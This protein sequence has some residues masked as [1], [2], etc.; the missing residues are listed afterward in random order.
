MNK[1]C[2]VLQVVVFLI[3]FFLLLPSF[4][5]SHIYGQSNSVASLN[6]ANDSVYSV[7]FYF[8]FK[9]D[10]LE[11]GYLTNMVSIVDVEKVLT[12]RLIFNSIDSIVVI[13]GTSPDG[14]FDYTKD[15]LTERKIEV[16]T[17]IH[18]KYPTIEREKVRISSTIDNQYI[19]KDLVEGD[20]NVPNQSAVLEILNQDLPFASIIQQLKIVDGGKSWDYMKSNLF[21]FMRMGKATIYL[22]REKSKDIERVKAELIVQ[23]DNKELVGKFIDKMIPEKS[24]DFTNVPAKTEY[25]YVRPLALKTNLLFDL[26]TIVNI[27]AEIPLSKNLSIAGECVFPWWLDEKKQR[28][29]EILSGSLEL[30]YWLNQEAR[31]QD[32]S[33]V[34]HNPL[35]GW[36]LG[37]YTG[38]GLYDLE[39][40]GKGYQGEFFIATG[41]SGGYVKPLSRNLNMEFSLGIGYLKTD[42]RRYEAQQDANKEWHLIKKNEGT[43]SWIGPIKAKVS[44]VWYPHFKKKGGRK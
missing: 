10:L 12:N 41:L 22:S 35:A 23:E 37:V 27:E 40:D 9:K 21:R 39:W 3:G 5:S 2:S 19:L 4:C 20:R 34:N 42:Y 30:R 38:G 16:K 8:R 15:L 43:Y 18:W 7:K 28:S 44:L 14:D 26:A 13:A 32:A 1:Q 24:L 29:L 33:L 11:K 17:Y 25:R 36:F 31:M 6:Y